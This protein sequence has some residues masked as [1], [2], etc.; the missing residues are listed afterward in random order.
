MKPIVPPKYDV[1]F[2]VKKCNLQ[3][4]QA[5][6]PWCS[7][8]YIEDTD[9]LTSHYLDLEQQHTKIDLTKKIKVIGY[10]VPDN[11]IVVEFDATKLNQESFNILMQLPEIIAE[12]GEVGTFELDIF[13][14]TINNMTTYEHDLIHIYNK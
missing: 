3:L 10:S 6:E 8:I 13:K 1:G 12:S 4:L 2:V 7:T 9:V 5:L 14:I 11:D